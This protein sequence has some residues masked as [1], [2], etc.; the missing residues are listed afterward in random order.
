MKKSVLVATVSAL[1]L[2]ACASNMRVVRTPDPHYPN[3]TIAGGK[4]IVVNQEPIVI[5]NNEK[6]TWI[7]WQL[8]VDSTYSFPADGI[9]IA[10]AGD[11]FKC[12]L[13]ADKKRF[14]CKDKNS[15]SGKY[16]YTIKVID[17]S[18]PLEPL[19]PF[20]MND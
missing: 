19:D 4:Y 9:V 18:K 1:V 15:K 3:V 11:E 2:T 20:I 13:E 10:N 6:D 14:A 12:N 7:T 8:P 16:K 17:G 5:P